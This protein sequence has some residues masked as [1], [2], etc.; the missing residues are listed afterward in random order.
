[1]YQM[2][3]VYVYIH[4]CIYKCMLCL[5]Q[6]KVTCK[7]MKQRSTAQVTGRTEMLLRI[8]GVSLFLLK[9]KDLTC[10]KNIFF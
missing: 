2:L 10:Q 1:M 5:S 9:K 8:E 7:G 3:Y 6:V 4:T